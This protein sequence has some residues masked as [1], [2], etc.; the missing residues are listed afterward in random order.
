MILKI[1]KFSA[2]I[3]NVFIKICIF[4]TKESMFSGK[5]S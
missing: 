5:A 2:I 1:R 3:L 4:D